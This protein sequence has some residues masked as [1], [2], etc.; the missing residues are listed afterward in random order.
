VTRC[1]NACK[2]GANCRRIDCCH[3]CLL[4]VR[5]RC[6][7]DGGLAFIPRYFVRLARA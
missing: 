3:E 1:A 6:T 7:N 4:Y 2:G 5:E